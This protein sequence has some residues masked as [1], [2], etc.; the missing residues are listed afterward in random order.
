MTLS[1]NDDGAATGVDAV[2]VE[3][4]IEQADQNRMFLR[5]VVP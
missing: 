2:T 3:V 1:V 4:D 5:L